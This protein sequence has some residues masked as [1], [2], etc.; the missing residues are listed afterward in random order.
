MLESENRAFKNR[1]ES[2]MGSRRRSRP[3]LHFAQTEHDG[4]AAEA[5]HC[6]IA[7]IVD[8]RPHSSLGEFQ[9]SDSMSALAAQY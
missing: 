9:L 1:G 8:V 3:G 7:K 4:N 6:Q 5:H 2:L